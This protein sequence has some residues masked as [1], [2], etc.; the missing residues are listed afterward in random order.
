MG[1]VFLVNSGNE[2]STPEHQNSASNKPIWSGL[3][4]RES[5]GG[6]FPPKTNPKQVDRFYIFFSAGSNLFRGNCGCGPSNHLDTWRFPHKILGA[7]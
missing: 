4:G 2:C 1:V 7:T 3:F 5:R 6:V